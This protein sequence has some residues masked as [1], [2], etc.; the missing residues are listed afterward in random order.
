VF[1]VAIVG[2]GPAGAWAAHLLAARGARVAIF[3]ASHP[4][5]KPCGGGVTGRALALIASAVDVESLPFVRVERATFRGRGGRTVDVPLP[6]DASALRVGSRTDFDGRLLE[7]AVA[8][9]AAHVP[10][11]VL[12]VER[13]GRGFR[14]HTAPGSHRAAFIVGA[15]GANSLIRRRVSCPFRREQLSVATGFFAH[16]V[17]SRSIVLELVDEPPGYIWSFPRPDHLAIGICAQASTG[18]STTAL[19]ARTARWIDETRIAAGRMLTPY[20]WPIP[21]LDEADIDS[22]EVSGPGWMLVGDAAGLVDPITREGI[23]FAIESAAFAADSLA[24]ANPERLY[25][26][27][28]HAGPLDEL[29]RA[30]RL[31]RGFFQPRFTRLLLDALEVSS[32]VRAVMA[33]LVAGA[34]G[35]RGLKWRLAKTMEVGLAWKV[36]QSRAQGVL[37]VRK[38]RIA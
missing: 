5:E 19:R 28:L 21:S 14:L 18:V 36:V 33:D 2:A 12:D 22:L 29:A 24:G 4:R 7:R 26:D 16:G 38:S 31:K 17:T 13:D 35:Y 34:Q 37:D 9:G 15:D 25:A 30:A 1:D 27:R 20:A 10:Q 8:S 11:R 32:G 6:A 23:F 3:D